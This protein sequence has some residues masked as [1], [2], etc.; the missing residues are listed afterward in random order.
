MKGYANRFA[1]IDLT[2]QTIEDYPVSD[3]YRKLYLGGKILA[4][5][6]VYDILKEKTDAYSPDNPI[7]ITTS[8]LNMSNAPSTSRFNVST[9]SP[10]TNL[11]TSSNCGGN[12]GLKLKQAGFDGLIIVGKAEKPTYIKVKD[13]NIE[14]LD[15]TPFWGMLTGEA[16]EKMGAKTEGKF[17]IGPAGE[18]LVRY[19]GVV[20][21]E[22]IAGRNGVGAVF[23]SKLLKGIVAGGSFKPEIAEPEKLKELIKKWAKHLTEHPLTGKQLPNYGTA[24]L[25]T[26]MNFKNLLATRNYKDGRYEDFEKISGETLREKYLVKNKGCITCPIQC[27]RV[28]KVEGKEVKGPEV[29]TVTLL[30]SNLLNSDMQK[31]LDANYY[32]DEYGMDTISFGSAI[33]FAMELNEKGMWDCGLNFG[34][35]DM[36]LVGIAKAVAY[37]EGIGNE[38]ADGTRKMSEK[39]GGKEFAINVKGLELAAYEPRAAQGMGLGYAT[40]NRGGCHLNGGY[41]VVMEGLGLN[42]SGMTT[43]GKAAF[44]IFFQDLMEAISAGGSCLFTSYAVLPGYAISHQNSKLLRAIFKLIPYFGGAVGLAHKFLGILALNL[45]SMVPYPV[46]INYVTGMKLTLGEYLRIGERGYNL[47]RLVNI[48]QGLTSDDDTLPKR[49]LEEPQISNKSVVRL[50]KMKNS[51]YK[52]R[53]WKDGVPTERVRR[54]LKI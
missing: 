33:G 11:L 37:R 25:I 5:R 36:D 12:F 51:Y 9:I 30:G 4:A 15:A 26:P 38:L 17:V 28:V 7:V 14:L 45:P 32:C 39:F 27:G 6:I 35:P 3:E 47:E 23:G 22:R 43:K 50:D 42:V 1:K 16:Q 20:S 18:N 34:D 31:I 54:K 29:E 10:L 21:Q 41:L 46:A 24:G 48:R 53:G 52:I 8:P 49:L 40:A 44:G 13:G 2:T 19:A